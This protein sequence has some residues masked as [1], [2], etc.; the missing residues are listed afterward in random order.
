MTMRRNALLTVG[1]EAGNRT[2]LLISSRL[3]APRL[4]SSNPILS[5]STIRLGEQRTSRDRGESDL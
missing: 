2:F 4:N 5:T 1:D 3:R